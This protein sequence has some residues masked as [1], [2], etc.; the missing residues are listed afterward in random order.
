LPLTGAVFDGVVMEFNGKNATNDG[1]ENATATKMRRTTR[2]HS[3]AL[4]RRSTAR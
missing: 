1:D 4:R 2:I 3:M